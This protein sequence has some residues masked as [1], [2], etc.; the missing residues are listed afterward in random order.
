MTVT[1]AVLLFSIAAPH[2]TSVRNWSPTD[3]ASGPLAI[4]LPARVRDLLEAQ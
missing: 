4:I 1:I 2:V 3:P